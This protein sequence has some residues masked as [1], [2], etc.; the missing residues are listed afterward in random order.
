MPEPDPNWLDQYKHV[1]VNL[2][3]TLDEALSLVALLSMALSSTLPVSQ[4]EAISIDLANIT[5]ALSVLNGKALSK[6]TPA[7]Q[8]CMI[9]LATYGAYKL[10]GEHA[11]EGIVRQAMTTLESDLTGKPTD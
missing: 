8:P 2:Q 9:G 6:V 10:A 5:I 11:M 1:V 4:D 7:P 3:M